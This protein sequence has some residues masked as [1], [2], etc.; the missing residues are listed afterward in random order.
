M[1]GKKHFYSSDSNSRRLVHVYLG[2]LGIILAYLL[3]FILDKYLITVS[4]WIDAPSVF[5]FYGLLYWLFKDFLWNK[6]LFRFLL[7]IKTPDWNGNYVGELKSS[8]DNFVNA[9][10]FTL[11]IHQTWDK[12]LLVGKTDTSDSFSLTAV[13][14]EVDKT[15]P[16]L[17]YEYQNQPKNAATES[18]N[19]HN[20]VTQLYWDNGELVG[21][22]YNGR[23]RRTFGTF[24]VK[25]IE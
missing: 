15:S 21:D 11:E 23:G 6:K 4:W 1:Q 18:M 24:K 5:G 3:Y 16:L 25:K 7:G 14:S 19:T 12:I 10:K 9:I 2:I 22:F 13:F 20:G 8:H 17:V